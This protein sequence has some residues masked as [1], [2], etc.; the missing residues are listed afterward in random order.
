MTRAC[1]NIDADRF[2]LTMDGHATGS[3]TVCA[4]CSAVVYALAGY[5]ANAGEHVTELRENTLESGRACLICRGD[6][7]VEAA[8]RMAGI[9]LAQI[10][11]QYP[12][13]VDAFFLPVEGM[14]H[15]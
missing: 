8:Y 14:Q 10:A 12:D 4:A 1:I 5:L 9:G 15:P 11:K 3:E 2:L 7:C 6:A 13:Y